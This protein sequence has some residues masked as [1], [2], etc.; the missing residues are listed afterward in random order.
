MVC[1]STVKINGQPNER[2]TFY[3]FPKQP[4]FRSS[5]ITGILVH[6]PSFHGFSQSVC[7][8]RTEK[9][10]NQQIEGRRRPEGINMMRLVHDVGENW[11]GRRNP[12]PFYKWFTP[13]DV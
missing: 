13:C 4:Y 9:G 8:I 7:H 11:F 10:E 3:A 1:F 2:L 5:Y 6:I 12:H